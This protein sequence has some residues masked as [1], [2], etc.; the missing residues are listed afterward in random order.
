VLLSYYTLF[1]IPSSISLSYS[2]EFQNVFTKGNMAE[3][4]VEQHRYG[5]VAYSIYI[6][7]FNC[8]EITKQV[9]MT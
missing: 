1:L 9:M 7:Y 3:L 2:A 8:Y 6:P 4:G 5:T